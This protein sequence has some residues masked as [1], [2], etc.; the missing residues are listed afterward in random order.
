MLHIQPVR[1]TAGYCGPASLKMLLDYHNVKKSEKELARLSGA[2]REK[3]VE[4]QGIVKAAK[5]LN[6]KA[7]IKDNATFEDIRKYVKGKKIPVIVDWFAFE[8]GHYSLVVDIDKNHIWLQDPE[9]GTLRAIRLTLF[10]TLWFDFPH[11]YIRTKKD[12]I[13]RRMIVI[14]P[15]SHSLR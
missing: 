3:G 15:P 6:F 13:L 1:Q 2:T 11:A 14:V 9:L 7:F 4:A 10:R 8:D 12:L 5:K